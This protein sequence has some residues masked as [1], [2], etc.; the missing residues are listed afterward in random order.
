MLLLLEIVAGGVEGV[1]VKREKNELNG[2]GE[3]DED[4]E[5]ADEDGGV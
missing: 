4:D 3:D 2:R 5:V 1:L